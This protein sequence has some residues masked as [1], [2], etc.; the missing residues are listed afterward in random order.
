MPQDASCWD[1][2]VDPDM[3]FL[4]SYIADAVCREGEA[5]ARARRQ[6]E[7]ESGEGG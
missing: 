3:A 7:D 4:D 5:N 2:E 6:E 1:L